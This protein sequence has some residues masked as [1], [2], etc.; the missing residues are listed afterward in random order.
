MSLPVMKPAWKTRIVVLGLAALFGLGLGV[1]RAVLDAQFDVAKRAVPFTLEGALNFRRVE[2]V[3][4]TGHVPDIDRDIQYPDGIVVDQTDTVGAEYVYAALAR[5]FPRSMPLANRIRWIEPAWFCLGIPLMAFWL[6]WWRRSLWGSAV[7]AAF[8]AVALSSVIRSTGQEV[9]HENFALPLLI[10]HLAFG[11]LAD[12]GRR[13][14]SRGLGLVLSAVRLAAALATWDLVQYYVVLWALV[15]FVRVIR[16]RLAEP[17]W[18]RQ[19]WGVQCLALAVVSEANPYLRAHAFLLSPAM[20]LCLG[21]AVALVVRS[22]AVR[23]WCRAAWGGRR[24]MAAIGLG[25]VLAAGFLPSPYHNAYGHFSEL[26]QA[27]LRW[28]NHK[29]ADP[30]VLSFDQRIMWVPAL[31]S[32]S[33]ALTRRLFPAM[34]WLTII[35]VGVFSRRSNNQADPGLFQLLFFYVASWAAFVLFVRFHVFLAVFSAA[36]LGV[37]AAWAA[38]RGGWRKAVVLALLLAGVGAEAAQVLHRPERWGRGPWVYYQELGELTR[39]LERY[40]SPESVLAN[41]GVSASILTYA[42]CPIILHPKFESPAI[43]DRVRSYG[44]ALFKGT[45]EDFWG[46]ANGRGAQYYVYAMGEFSTIAPELQMR[47][48]VDALNPSTNCPAWTF[49][50]APE[51]AKHFRLLWGNRKYRV[52]KVRTPRDGAVAGRFSREAREAL[53]QGDLDRAE[54]RA[55]ATLFLKPQDAEAQDVVKHVGSLRDQGFQNSGHER[56]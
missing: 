10:G 7:G 28:L 12:A 36:L 24:A 19:K 6:W 9:S 27:K 44:E 3:F 15:S 13:S 50:F 43:R 25:F 35:S 40:A 18:E 38:G 39:W 37:W 34:F 8:Y 29:P 17:G 16:G 14:W 26:L 31:D 22:L 20:M 55:V 41:F 21:I 2:Q 45:E 5:L 46:W 49:E 53:E 4:E 23:G 33:W 56:E 51:R 42:E 48:F 47:Y 11:A 52:F 54:D 30:S 1:R 32:A